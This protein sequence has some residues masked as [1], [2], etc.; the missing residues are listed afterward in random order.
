MSRQA[1]ATGSGAHSFALRSIRVIT[2]M[3]E[4]AVAIVSDR[5]RTAVGNRRPDVAF[6]VWNDRDEDFTSA[7]RRG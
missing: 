2:W 1:S 3:R 5:I 4:T 6:Q 7:V